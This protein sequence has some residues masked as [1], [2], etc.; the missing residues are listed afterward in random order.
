[1]AAVL[2]SLGSINAD[3]QVKVDHEPGSAET[4]LAHD[5]LRLCGGKAANTAYLGSLFGLNSH[6]LGRVG[7]DDL[8]TQVLQSLGQAGV[9]I[10]GVSRATDSSTAVSMII[11]PP[12]GKKQIVLAANANDSW[13][14]TSIKQVLTC[15][16]NSPR[17]ACLVIDAEIDPMVTSQA[18]AR[19]KVLGI[20]VVLDPSFPERVDPAW[21]DELTAITPN[22]EEASILL[23]AK[24][25]S[26][27]E[28]TQAA[29]QLFA[30]GVRIACIKLR[31]GGAVMAH[32]EG[33]YQIPSGN[34]PVVD[35]TGAGDAFTGVLAISLLQGFAPLQAACRAVAA[36]DIAV[37]RY[38]SQPSYA[39]AD[40][41]DE[42]ARATEPR[43]RRLHG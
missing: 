27:E 38:G 4:L 26:L 32:A 30:R 41:V 3:F 5:F 35:S 33:T 24:A 22:S 36:S 6:L 39:A 1:M 15:I 34:V 11:V 31:N 12:E 19:A 21:L 9:N 28:A 16:D 23:G 17:P 40:R 7:D 2:I 10:D 25:D 29:S 14:E 8:A 43:V 37:T 42:H 18:I 13:N 20:P